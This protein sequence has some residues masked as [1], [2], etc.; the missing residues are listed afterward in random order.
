MI[1]KFKPGKNDNAKIPGVVQEE[2]IQHIEAF[3]K[4][5]L[6][7]GLCKYV[8][9]IQEKYLYLTRTIGN[10]SVEQICRLRYTDDIN[11]MDFAIY[12]Y[13]T[14]K[15]SSSECNFDGYKLV[16]GTVEGAMKAG[17]KAYPI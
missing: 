1:I 17:L 7:K 13:S 8:P 11:N 3:N 2:L 9:K 6:S 15:Y 12:K 4:K 5:H 16:D 10:G 14:E